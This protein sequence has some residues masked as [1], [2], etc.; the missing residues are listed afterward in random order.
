MLFWPIPF[1]PPDTVKPDPVKNFQ[2]TSAN[3]TSFDLQWNSPLD[4]FYRHDEILYQLTFQSEFGGRPW[5]VL[6]L[7]LP[8]ICWSQN[9]SHVW[10]VH[11][12]S[13]QIDLISK[14]F[15][16]R[17]EMPYLTPF[18]SYTISIRCAPFEGV[19]VHLGKVVG[20]YSNVTS[21]QAKTLES[22]E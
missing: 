8:P 15:K 6:Q 4:S 9:C 14:D 20:Y 18:T 19:D 3:D 1:P 11:V 12:L 13:F 17:T 5:M 2:V 16:V 22:G 10:T 21:V 7:C